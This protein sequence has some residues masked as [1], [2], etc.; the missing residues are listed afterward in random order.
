MNAWLVVGAL[1]WSVIGGSTEC[2]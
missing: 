2:N 1:E